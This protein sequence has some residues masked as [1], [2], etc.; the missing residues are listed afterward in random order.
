MN[1]QVGFAT[2]GKKSPGFMLVSGHRRYRNVGW[3]E[4]HPA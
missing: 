1:D 2:S 4:H 3:L